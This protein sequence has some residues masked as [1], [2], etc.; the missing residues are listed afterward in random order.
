MDT[1]ERISD[2][3][4]NWLSPE[5][6][7]TLRKRDADGGS[8]E[9]FWFAIR[10]AYEQNLNPFEDHVF[11]LNNYS[12]TEGRE[13]MT[14]GTSI[15]GLRMIAQQ[16]GEYAG[17]KGPFW[18]GPDGEWVDVWLKDEPPAAAKVGVL[19]DGFKEP[20]WN[21]ARWVDYCPT[22]KRGNPR[23]MWAD[24]GPLMLAKCSEANGLRRAFPDRASGLYIQEEMEK[25]DA[26]AMAG[27][28]APTSSPADE[29][30]EALFG[31]PDDEPTPD[32]AAAQE[33]ESGPQTSDRPNGTQP[34]GS[35]PSHETEAEGSAV[36]TISTESQDGEGKGQLGYL[37]AVGVYEGPYTRDGLKRMIEEE[38]GVEQIDQLPKS[39]FDAAKELLGK[40]QLAKRY[41]D[42]AAGKDQ[43]RDMFD[44]EGE[45]ATGADTPGELDVRCTYCGAEPGAPCE[46]SSGNEKDGFHQDRTE[47]FKAKA[48][49]TEAFIAQAIK[50]IDQ[51]DGENARQDVMGAIA[52]EIAE[53]PK[54]EWSAIV[55]G[56]AEEHA[57]FR[58]E[59]DFRRAPDFE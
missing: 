10:K 26:E 13:V 11:F 14:L 59:A 16:T 39:D 40:D 37:F 30:G 9:D 34:Q 4:D 28:E 43:T 22:D 50:A 33:A 5:D 48:G 20:L 12:K 55:D 2:R 38:F 8:I 31:E 44:A 45:P 52:V 49:N 56:V 25:E 58:N 7:K 23:F 29:L 6:L 41:N 24:K 42:Q 3:I 54:A 46:T 35:P 32:Q 17:Q 51:A 47:R 15:H 21:V 53:R 1:F 18:C 19:R 36:E 57:N 27:E